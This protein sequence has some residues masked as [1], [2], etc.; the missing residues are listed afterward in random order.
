MKLLLERFNKFWINYPK[1]RNK[2]DAKRI[3]LKLKPDDELLKKMLTKIME[4]KSSK[5]W[6]DFQYIP[7][8]SSWLNA[9]GWED[10][11][12]KV[13]YQV[14]HE[15]KPVMPRPPRK[16]T[17]EERTILD[18]MNDLRHQTKWGDKESM[19]EMTAKMRALQ[20]QYNDLRFGTRKI[21]NLIEG[22]YEKN[23]K[24]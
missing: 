18:K 10:E 1:K 21:G 9:M 15:E 22:E 11:I 6:K 13:K 3:W 20:K 23:N 7:Y 14:S 12:E 2:G 16:E 24:D 4:F 17:P 5:E 8:P 19:V